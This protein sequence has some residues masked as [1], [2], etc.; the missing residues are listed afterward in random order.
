MRRLDAAATS[1]QRPL[2]CS[3]GN[4]G[5]RH[6]HRTSQQ[7]ASH[8]AGSLDWC[9]GGDGRLRLLDVAA[10]SR[11]QPLRLVNSCAGNATSTAPD[12]P[13]SIENNKTTLERRTGN[14]G[15]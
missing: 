12:E 8:V 10:T 4:F 2:S 1:W 6:I 14:A 5:C 3:P 11:R 15:E 7:R 13:P 9:A